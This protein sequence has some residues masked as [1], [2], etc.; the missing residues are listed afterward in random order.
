[1]CRSCRRNGY[2]CVP[3]QSWGCSFRADHASSSP[4]WH[5]RR[6]SRSSRISSCRDDAPKHRLRSRSCATKPARAALDSLDILGVKE[7]E[8]LLIVGATGGIG[9]YATQLAAHRGVKVIATARPET[10]EYIREL[11]ASEIVD[12]TK[13]DIADTI[14]SSHP[15]G[16]DA[17][18]DVVSDWSNL[19]R[20]SK[21][22]RSRGRVVSTVYAANAEALASGGIQGTNLS[23]P[24]TT[25]KME[26]LAK[27]VDDGKLKIPVDKV[28]PLER[29]VEALD[30]VEHGRVRG[31]VVIKIPG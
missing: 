11:G 29:G 1:M 22:L 28:Y 15:S 23:T 6:I 3:V 27:L 18:L 30:Q 26:R 7:G 16:I 2:E 21:A 13:G 8:T 20:I 25:E 14:R 4:L 5:L 24:I 19:E 10:A 12:F 17:V 9:S 31:K